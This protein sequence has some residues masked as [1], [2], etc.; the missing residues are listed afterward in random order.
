MVSPADAVMDLQRKEE[1]SAKLEELSKIKDAELRD[2]YVEIES[3]KYKV[4]FQITHPHAWYKINDDVQI[5]VRSSPDKTAE[6]IR[7]ICDTDIC[8]ERYKKDGFQQLKDK[9][10]R[11]NIIILPFC[12]L[13]F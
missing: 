10:V 9:S 13:D 5:P 3:F 6:V 2:A 8:V 12:S 7:Y 11:I 4:Q 1:C